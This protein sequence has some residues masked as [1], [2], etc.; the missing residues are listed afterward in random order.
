M[1]LIGPKDIEEEIKKEERKW[2]LYLR[3]AMGL[4]RASLAVILM[5][6]F[7][8]LLNFN[9]TRMFV[10][11]IPIYAIVCLISDQIVSYFDPKLAK[12]IS[13]TKEDE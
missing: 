13:S 5:H 8:S 6:V 4:V 7:G 3:F 1:E 12:I 2:N 11:F 10:L 9:L